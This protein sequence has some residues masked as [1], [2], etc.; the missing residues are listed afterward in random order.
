MYYL[1]DKKKDSSYQSEWKC[2]K[3]VNIENQE[4]LSLFPNSNSIKQE[5]KANKSLAK[6]QFFQKGTYNHIRNFQLKVD[7]F[8]LMTNQNRYSSRWK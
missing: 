2:I 8:R 4:K 3:N 5:K 6:K 1:I 7:L